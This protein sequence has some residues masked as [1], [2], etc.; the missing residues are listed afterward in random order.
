M[1][2][3]HGQLHGRRPAVFAS[4][5]TSYD[6]S[7]LVRTGAREVVHLVPDD[8]D[9]PFAVGFAGKGRPGLVA[10]RAPLR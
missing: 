3:G 2:P 6:A 1:P 7:V 8:G 10:W 5:V 9:K 4:A